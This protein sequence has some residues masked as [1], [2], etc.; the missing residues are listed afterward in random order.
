MCATH[1]PIGSAHAAPDGISNGAD[2]APVTCV[3]LAAGLGKRM[4]AGVESK[5]LVVV[6]GLA[7][8]E[9]AIAAAHQ[10]GVGDFVVI[11]GFHSDRIDAF[12]D[13]LRRRRRVA[14]TSRYCPFWER[15]NGASLR[16]ARDV[17]KGPFLLLMADHVMDDRIIQMLLRHRLDGNDLILAV[18]RRVRN[19]DGVDLHDV[20]RV[21][22]TDDHIRAIGKGL[23]PFN[24][25]DTGAFI[26]TPAMFDALDETLKAG[27]GSLNGA[28]QRL[29][30]AGSAITV[31]IGDAYWADVDTL[32][33]R[34]EVAARLY[35][36]LAKPNDGW[37]SRTLNRP[38]SLRLFTPLLLRFFRWI[39]PNQ[40][41]ALGFLVG[42]VGAL[43][44]ML[45]Q[46]IAA[47]IMIHLASVVDGSDG[48]IAR[49]KMLASPL[50]SFL[51]AVLDRYADAAILLG[52]TYFVWSDRGIA[53]L[54]GPTMPALTILTGLLAV[55]G[56]LMVSYTSTKAQDDL[57]YRYAGCW[58]ASGRGRD[59]RLMVLAIGA[60]LAAVHGVSAFV[61]LA[62]IAISTNAI[63]VWRAGV[64][65]RHA[66]STNP[67]V[68]INVKAVVFDFDG[69]VADTMSELT[70]ISVT[71]L[72]QHYGLGR[73]EAR[74][75][76][77]M[78]CGLPFR[79]QLEELFPADS[80]NDTV[81]NEFEAAKRR[82]AAGWRPFSGAR[83]T[84]THLKGAGVQTFLCSSS[85]RELV[86]AFVVAN[87]LGDSF[88]EVLGYDG[89]QT[90]DLQMLEIMHKHG[91]EARDVV[92]VGDSLHDRE[93]AQRAGVTFIGLQRT[94]FSADF[95]A[96]RIPMVASLREFKTTWQQSRYLTAAVEST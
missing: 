50:G 90:K 75:R 19:N 61:A 11:T 77:L 33:E 35:G 83:T 34:R 10:A 80:R 27:D 46:P 26:C 15:G 28:V 8:L 78:T 25:F 73:R 40:V 79:S 76:Y 1:E 86:H 9:R 67:L 5:P 66:R 81:A 68:G 72:T 95:T 16:C 4:D 31:G 14:I 49:L 82:G 71:L 51:D 29:A 59:W 74:K 2:P 94:S 87:R 89:S 64:S 23:D 42:L 30:D 56:T 62:L 60:L 96:H 48:E 38:L 21:H 65:W 20:T 44:L 18:D 32:A 13:D 88:T 84:L 58:I 17:V 91:L 43:C 39:T 37:V 41:S 70:A 54:L 24:A 3:I 69:T 6:A 12:L 53:E 47:G 22:V 92:F 52:L 55:A 63:V 36:Q 45:R 7:L 57:G 85:T 93:F